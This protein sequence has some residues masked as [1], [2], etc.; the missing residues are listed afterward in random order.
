MSKTESQR[1]RD[2]SGAPQKRQQFYLYACQAW[3]KQY[4]PDIYEAIRKEGLKLYPSVR[5]ER[6]TK[7]TNFAQRLGK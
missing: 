3:V 1:V 4:R 6:K 2:G 7:V 5:I